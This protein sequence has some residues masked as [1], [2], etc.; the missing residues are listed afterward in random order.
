MVHGALA[1]FAVYR[2]STT[3]HELKKTVKDLVAERKAFHSAQVDAQSRRVIPTRILVRPGR[4]ASTQLESKVYALTDRFAE[5]A[6]LV[7][8][9]QNVMQSE[10]GRI[11]SFCKKT[12]HGANRCSS[13]PNRDRRCPI[14]GKIG[15]SETTCWSKGRTGT[16]RG[17]LAGA[18]SESIVG[19]RTAAG[20]AGRPEENISPHQHQVTIV[21][22]TTVNEVV[23][24]T[25]RDAEG[26]AI[27]KQQRTDEQQK[28]QVYPRLQ[29]PQMR[30]EYTQLGSQVRSVRNTA[31]KAKKTRARKSKKNGIQEHVRKYSVL[32]ELANVPS[33]LTFGQ[34]V[35]GDADEAK[36]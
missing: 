18:R 17:S 32:S 33:G 19:G 30:T 35:R 16:G 24:A 29:N 22:E 36:K 34:L 7:K 10:P 3:Y 26:E 6:L 1:Q 21:T 14:C 31:R 25:R 9:N 20:A 27:P 8:K 15:Y 5:L 13:N 28:L 11:C 23:A 2:G 4:A 12:G